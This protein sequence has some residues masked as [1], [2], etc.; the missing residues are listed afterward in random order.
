MDPGGEVQWVRRARVTRPK[1]YRER[2]S[3]STG[4]GTAITYQR[5]LMAAHPIDS[6]TLVAW[7]ASAH[8]PPEFVQCV[9]TALVD[10][11]PGASA[12]AVAN[13]RRTPPQSPRTRQHC[14]IWRR[15]GPERSY[16]RTFRTLS[17]EHR[18]EI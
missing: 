11:D 5:F 1:N 12:G 14:G 13:K 18:N 7:L 8:G 4:S 9:E 16:M 6:L 3:K 17:A 15:S 10:V 2:R